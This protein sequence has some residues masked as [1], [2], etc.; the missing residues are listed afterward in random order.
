MIVA[1][2]DNLGVASALAKDGAL[3]RVFTRRRL[4]GAAGVGTLALTNPTWAE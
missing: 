3:D 1:L 4:L 2:L